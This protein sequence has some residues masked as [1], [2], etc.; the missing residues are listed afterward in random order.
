VPA[1]DLQRT[2]FPD[3]IEI[4]R[5]EWH[6]GMSFPDLIELCDFLDSMLR[7]IRSTRKIRSPIFKCLACGRIGS[8]A[9]PRV[10]VRAMILSLAQ[11][12]IAEA[13]DTKVLERQWAVCRQNNKLDLYGKAVG[14]ESRGD[15]C[16]HSTVR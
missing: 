5:T 16:A 4:L 6:V 15:A 12:K 9:E 1:G 14:G 3:V 13:Q 10:R 7:E 11:F 8:G 2:W